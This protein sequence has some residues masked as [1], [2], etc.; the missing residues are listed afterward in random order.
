[1]SIR[2]DCRVGAR[3]A[4]AIGD[5]RL[6][7]PRPVY[8]VAIHLAAATRPAANQ[9]QPRGD[10]GQSTGSDS[11]SRPAGRGQQGTGPRD[12]PLIATDARRSALA[13]SEAGKVAPAVG[14]PAAVYP[15]GGGS[16]GSGSSGGSGGSGLSGRSGGG[17]GSGQ[18]VAE[19][20]DDGGHKLHT[21]QRRGPVAR[22]I[23]AARPAGTDRVYRRC[24]LRRS[25]ARRSDRGRDQRGYGYPPW[26]RAH[27][28][29]GDAK[30]GNTARP[31]GGCQR[32]GSATD[33][34]G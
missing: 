27:G 34:A 19:M 30:T 8:T 32:R 4:V 10:G 15:G 33:R 26:R 14:H 24:P 31:C 5:G 6:P 22:F 7:E 9:A 25:T 12:Q 23:G 11:R 13:R 1:M 17:S 16:S 21:A 3:S 18:E 28:D 2:C 20:P 29:R